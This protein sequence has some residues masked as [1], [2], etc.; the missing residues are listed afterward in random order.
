KEMYSS[1]LLK[2]TPDTR[3]KYLAEYHKRFL[4]PLW[5]WLSTLLAVCGV[6]SS[7]ITGRSRGKNMIFTGI[8]FVGLQAFLLSGINFI[9]TN[10]IF[11]S[12][13]YAIHIIL[14]LA[15]FLYLFS[16]KK[17]KEKK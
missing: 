1:R 16:F 6:F 2:Y 9:K 10:L 3:K 5:V 4:T 7:S 17:S 13:L 12:G 11:V 8:G 15:G 14:I